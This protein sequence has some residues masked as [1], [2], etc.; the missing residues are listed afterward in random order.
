[1]LIIPD[2]NFLIYMTDYRLWHEFENLCGIYDLIILPQ[3]VYELEELSQKGN[4]SEKKSALVALEILKKIKKLPKKEEGYADD[5]IIQTSLKLKKVNKKNFA[6][7]TMDRELKDK[8]K[9]L[10]IKTLAIRQKKYI[11]ED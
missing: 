1:M 8:L 6:V 7:A 10:N 9:K 11:I 4:A 5:V 3:I 2:T